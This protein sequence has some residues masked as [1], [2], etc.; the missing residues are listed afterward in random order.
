LR[1]QGYTICGHTVLLITRD[2][3]SSSA[4]PPVQGA[5][6]R[7]CASRTQGGAKTMPP[8]HLALSSRPT[9]GRYLPFPER[10]DIAIELA[11]RAGIR[12]IAHKLGRTPARF[13]ASCDA[14][15][16]REAGASTIRRGRHNGMLTGPLSPR[17]G[18][19]AMNP[20]LRDYVQDRLAGT[21]TNPDG[22]VFSLGR[23]SSNGTA[24]RIATTGSC[25]VS[26]PS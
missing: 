12:A 13:R 16:P 11:K 14:M 25:L 4:S 3:H 22:V 1:I 24:A 2:Y 9:S 20:V 7:R 5:E 15:P 17:L 8:T 21:I 18:K 26:S 19:L 23:N 6:T 10:K